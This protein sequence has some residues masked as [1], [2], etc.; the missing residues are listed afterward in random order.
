MPSVDELV[1]QLE[2]LDTDS[3]HANLYIDFKKQYGGT[4]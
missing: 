4:I 1:E 3:E 2:F